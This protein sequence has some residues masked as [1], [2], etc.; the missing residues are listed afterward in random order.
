M[1]VL[2]VTLESEGEIMS[3][4]AGPGEPG[5]R[6]K[7]GSHLSAATYADADSA[8]HDARRPQLLRADGRVEPV[9]PVMFVVAMEEL[10]IHFCG[11]KPGPRKGPGQTTMIEGND[12]GHPV[13]D[14]GEADVNEPHSLV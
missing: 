5:Y 14:P 7:I 13:P 12:A 4:T 8:W 1:L 11:P 9:E 10:G 3:I 6:Y 2:T